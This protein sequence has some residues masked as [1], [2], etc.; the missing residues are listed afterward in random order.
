MKDLVWKL[1][2]QTGKIAYY[3]LYKE[4]CGNGCDNEGRSTESNGLQGE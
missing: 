1:F 3:K 4:L 2:E